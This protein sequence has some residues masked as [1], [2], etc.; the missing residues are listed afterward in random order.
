MNVE[1]I[2]TRIMKTTV[3]NSY[4]ILKKTILAIVLFINLFFIR[5]VNAQCGYSLDFDATNNSYVWTSAYLDIDNNFTMEFWVKPGKEIKPNMIEQDAGYYDG[6]NGQN[7]AIWPNWYP[8][9]TYEA[10]VGVSVG[11]NGI[12]IFEHSIE[13]LPAL[14]VLYTP[15]SSTSWTHIA[16]VYTNKTPT[17]YINGVFAKTGLTSNR[18]KVH[19][20]SSLGDPSHLN[21]GPFDGSIDEVRVWAVSLSAST[22]S[23]WYNKLVSP[24]HP[25]YSSLNTYWKLDE[26]AGSV[27][28]DASGN[29][30]GG[31]L[32]ES[33]LL[34]AWTS[35]TW[36]GASVIVDA[37]PDVTTYFGIAS[38]QQVTRTAA[39][40]GGTPPYTFSWTLSRPLLCNQVTAN[41]DES[42]YGG[43]CMENT[44]PESGSPTVTP[45]C[46][47]SETI[48]AILLDTAEVCVTVTDANGCTASDCFTLNASDVRC[49]SG[50]GG[51]QKV[52]M[53]HHT[54]SPVNPWVE[55]CVDPDAINSHLAHGDY[56]GPCDFTKTSSPDSEQDMSLRLKLFP[57]PA[58]RRVTL[59]FESWAELPYVIEIADMTGRNLM[60]SGGK[61]SIGENTFEIGLEGILDGIYTIKL[62]LGG[63]CE[64]RK[65]MIQ[66]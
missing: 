4:P 16:V 40:S 3:N 11:T 32:E 28:S 29:G 47:G 12:A 24:S 45:S 58:S 19:P 25:N 49:F 14:L 15:I 64:V 52:K 31:T 61:A 36:I 9:Y 17:L 7:Y 66:H 51:N 39:A 44:C 60:E 43:T 41:G 18:P 42:F 37:G 1:P 20:S 22:I 6:I 38:M 13:Y 23:G 10:G 63:N 26:G 46:S 34:P 30:H 65:L 2:K 62:S 59:E 48:T 56:L 53:C 50:S 8:T 5:N 21:Y 55:I 54:N 33:P 57:N 27:V 35:D